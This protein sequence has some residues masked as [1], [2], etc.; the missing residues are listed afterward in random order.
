MDKL[1][2]ILNAYADKGYA[3][4]KANGISDVFNGKTVM[5]D[6]FVYSNNTLC[7]C[8]ANRDYDMHENIIP[9]RCITEVL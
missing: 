8:L 2:E 1:Q 4:V 9:V 3:E 6:D 5:V 7:V